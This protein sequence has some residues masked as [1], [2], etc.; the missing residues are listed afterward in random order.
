MKWFITLVGV[1]VILVAC[2]NEGSSETK[3]DNKE[4][5]ASSLKVKPAK[6][7]EREQSLVNQ[8]G[9]DYQT[10]YTVDGEVEEGEV[11]VT[12][13]V[14]IK[15]G[16]QTEEALTSVSGTGEKYKKD[17]HSFQLQMEKEAAY[18]TIG[19]HNGYV[20][21]STAIPDN[22]DSFLFEQPEEEIKI[23]KGEPIY[24]AYLIGSSQ[25]QLS[26]QANSDL[27][28]LPNSVKDAEYAAVFKVELKEE[29]E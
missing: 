12:S 13:I 1:M 24:L 2:T 8:I 23:T 11:L 22:I 29:T 19:S 6:L 21:G 25:N 3:Q 20:R 26:M 4:T 15:K 16:E 18:L 5:S 17:L 28:T 27:T 14:V 7:S 10:F 9:G